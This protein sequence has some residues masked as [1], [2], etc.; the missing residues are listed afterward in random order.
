MERDADR[1]GGAR[2]NGHGSGTNSSVRA[3]VLEG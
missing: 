1:V 2:R 3:M